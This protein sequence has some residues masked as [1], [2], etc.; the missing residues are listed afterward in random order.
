MERHHWHW[1]VHGCQHRI[2]QSQFGSDHPIIESGH[3]ARLFLLVLL[4]SACVCLLLTLDGTCVLILC[5]QRRSSIPVICCILAIFIEDKIPSRKEVA[6][7]VILS[8]GV[9]IA[10]WE[11]SVNGSP[12]GITLCVVGTVC[13]AAMM[14]TSGRILSE[15]LD[16]LRLAFYTAPVSCLALFPFCYFH[17]VSFENLER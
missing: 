4:M 12:R 17:E 15:K 8:L 16:V 2:Q 11:G 3:Q 10:V 14:S 5:C 1:A 13:N 7:L 6:S 9:M